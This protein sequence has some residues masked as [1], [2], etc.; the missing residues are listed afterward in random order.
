MKVEFLNTR[1]FNKGFFK[2]NW[3]KTNMVTTKTPNINVISTLGEVKPKV[4]MLLKE[5]SKKPKP[6]VEYTTESLSNFNGFL[7]SLLLTTRTPSIKI[8]KEKR[9]TTKKGNNKKGHTPTIII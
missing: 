6:K 4:P 7:S 8:I 2:C 9:A 5:K 1:T 3:R